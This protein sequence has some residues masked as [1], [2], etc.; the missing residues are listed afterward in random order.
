MT[1]KPEAIDPGEIAE[2]LDRLTKSDLLCRSATL[3]HLLEYLVSKAL[4]GEPLKESVIALELFHRGEN[5]D[6]K[7]DN[8]VRVHAHRLRRVLDTW[9]QGEGACDKVRFSIPRGS[10]T[11]HIDRL[12][13]D[14][15][16]SEA[17]PDLQLSIEAIEARAAVGAP[18][19]GVRPGRIGLILA[20]LG[21]FCAGGAAMYAGLRWTGRLAPAAEGLA[22]APL[23]AI[24]KSI[25][26][27]GVDCVVSFTNPLFLRTNDSVSRAY[28]TY[29][30]PLTAPVGTEFKP[31]S[32]DPF[33]NKRTAG[34]GP[35]YF[36][37]SWTG[38]GEMRAVHK[39][40]EMAA[41]SGHRF[42]LVRGRAL[43]YDDMKGSNVIFLGSPWANDMQ[44]KFNIGMTPFQCFGTEKIVNNDP[45]NG[46]PAAYFPELNPT[47]KELIAS[48]GLFSVLPGLTPG[49]KI[50][51]SS[52]IDQYATLAGLDLTTSAEG[53]R[54][55]MRRF[56]SLSEQTLP[57]YFQAVIRT[58]II[59]GDPANSS[60]VA[61]RALQAKK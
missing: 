59:R 50:V 17:E 32:G 37:E 34:L 15:A 57:E 22:A 21:C 2:H 54:E 36:N 10:Y 14:G 16:K 13:G 18:P 11:V 24:W 45:H 42:R 19:S 5:F 46:E 33:L 49:T 53:V 58:E 1:L 26:R 4:Q 61:V 47:T 56:G 7:V 35:L 38:I 60:V 28:V 9:Y 44:A 29:N 27:P 51:S 3:S 12:E 23:A 55:L 20:L 8:I 43:T 30:G 39:L 6:G 40:S 41:A 48:Y 52:G 31:S 25:F